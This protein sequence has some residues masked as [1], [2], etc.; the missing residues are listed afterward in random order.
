MDF[1]NKKS[2]YPMRKMVFQNGAKILSDPVHR[3]EMHYEQ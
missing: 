1:K 2:Q 3:I